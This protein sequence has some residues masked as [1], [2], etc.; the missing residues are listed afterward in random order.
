VQLHPRTKLELAPE[1]PGAQTAY[2]DSGLKD[3]L[4]KRFDDELRGRDPVTLEE[5]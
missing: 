1:Y 2:S 3:K 5:D 4:L